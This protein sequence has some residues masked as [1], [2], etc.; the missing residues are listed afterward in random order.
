MEDPMDEFK[1]YNEGIEQKKDLEKMCRVHKINMKKNI[2]LT[3]K[4]GG[5]ELWLN[6]NGGHGNHAMICLN[7]I[8]ND[9]RGSIAKKA[10]IEAISKELSE[11]KSENLYP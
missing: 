3:R 2:Y 9:Q 11:P 1:K 10:M 5:K 7:N 8:A 4:N 6:F